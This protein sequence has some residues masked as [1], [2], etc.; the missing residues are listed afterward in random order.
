MWYSQ[1]S[2]FLPEERKIKKDVE[3]KFMK[4]KLQK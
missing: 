3:S 2:T 1:K 4:K